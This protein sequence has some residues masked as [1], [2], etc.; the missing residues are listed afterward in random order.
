[1]LSYFWIVFLAVLHADLALGKPVPALRVDSKLTPDYVHSEQVDAA[2]TDNMSLA[3]PLASVPTV[4]KDFAT[5][6]FECMPIA[7]ATADDCDGAINWLSDKVSK[8]PN[9]AANVWQNFC[10]SVQNGNC[11]L[12]MCNEGSAD[13]ANIRGD[14][15]LST[16]RDRMQVQCGKPYWLASRA[17]DTAGTGGLNLYLGVF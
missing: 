8:N 10:F 11:R 16:F 12:F 14:V 4:A 1:M 15:V 17:W 6:D 5:F 3:M 2:G 13:I 9:F 7:G